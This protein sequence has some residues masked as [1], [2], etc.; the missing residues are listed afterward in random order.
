[1]ISNSSAERV[2]CA[3]LETGADF[4]E[5]FAEDCD[6]NRLTMSDGRIE[7]SLSSHRHGAGV[8]VMRGAQSAYA[9]TADTGEAALIDTA[10]AAAAAL[11]GSA[12]PHTLQ[13]MKKA[14]ATPQKISLSGVTNDRRVA[15]MHQAHAA[16]KAVCRQ[17][18]Q[19]AGN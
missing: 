10:R 2:L 7:Q 19:G 13:F 12:K 6:R 3:A 18:Q 15:L 4:A 5:L 1:M 8:R 11:S 17:Q 16:G 14:Y 9:Y